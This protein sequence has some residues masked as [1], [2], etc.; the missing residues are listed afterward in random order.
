CRLVSGELTTERL[1]PVLKHR[2]LNL[3]VDDVDRIQ[4]YVAARGISSEADWQETWTP[5]PGKAIEEMKEKLLSVLTPL[6]QSA[7]QPRPAEQHADLIFDL[8]R[9]FE[10][11]ENIVR[12]G[13]A[14]ADKPS[15]DMVS[16]T[17]VGIRRIHSACADVV[18]YCRLSRRAKLG[19]GGFV[20]MLQTAIENTDAH[21]ASTANAVQISNVFETRAPEYRAVFLP[22]LVEKNFPRQMRDNPFLKDSERGLLRS[23]EFDLPLKSQRASEERYLFY[24]ACTRASERLYFSYPLADGRRKA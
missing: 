8:F 24:I 13:K 15:E 9:Q 16:S 10:I 12:I 23:T 5:D 11:A 6:Q 17:C 14:N 4:E 19:F 7:S 3:D 22:N 21:T 20:E 18:D 1:I 2:L